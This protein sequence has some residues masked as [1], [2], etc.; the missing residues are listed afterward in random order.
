MM[1][2]KIH[3]RAD[4]GV[5]RNA[6][7]IG[8]Y[9]AGGCR[10]CVRGHPTAVLDPALCRARGPRQLKQFKDVELNRVG[11]AAAAG[12]A[13]NAVKPSKLLA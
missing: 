13:E 3:R 6:A 7:A 11:L 4:A 2:L 9:G 5:A 10:R 8:L 12:N 1:V